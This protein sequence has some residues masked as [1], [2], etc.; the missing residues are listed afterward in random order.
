MLKVITTSD[1]SH[2][3][4]IPEMN[5][6]Y[7]SVNGAVTESNYVFLEKGY[8][9]HKKE[10]PK[11]FEVGFGTGLNCLLTALKAEEKKRITTYYTIEKYPLEHNITDSL[12]YGKLIS[13]K[14]EDLYKKI[15]ESSWNERNE[16]SDYFHLIKMNSDLL[17]DEL[18]HVPP[19]DIIYF[20][21]FGPDKQP[22]M[23]HPSIFEKIYSL[24]AND[25]VFVTYSAKG[26]VRRQLAACGFEM[27][28][29]PGPPGK[30]Q[31]L[32]G[33]KTMQGS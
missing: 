3:L 27:E 17:E 4:Y 30:F 28:R 33:I 22:E 11:L 18:Q 13:E 14:A 23:W 5:E 8:M 6:Q 12:N 10:N 31:M 25:G 2:T 19:C 15:H 9:F 26:V 29:L 24:T 20:D 32:R 7:H 21:A 1:G 16:V